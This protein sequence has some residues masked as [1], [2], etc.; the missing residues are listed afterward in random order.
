MLGKTYFLFVLYNKRAFWC[1]LRRAV[2]TS[3]K[4]SVLFILFTDGFGE[5]TPCARYMAIAR[6][7][8]GDVVD[9]GEWNLSQAT[10]ALN[11]SLTERLDVHDRIVTWGNLFAERTRE[12]C[13]SRGVPVDTY[14]NR[15]SGFME[16]LIAHIRDHQWFLSQQLGREV[17]ISE[18]PKYIHVDVV[19][20]D[21]LEPVLTVE[22][23]AVNGDPDATHVEEIAFPVL[24]AQL[25]N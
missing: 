15:L 10:T 1:S 17:G 19:A 8:A 22:F 16:D 14:H 12:V 24:E 2:S 4:V 25:A 6:N 20:D 23:P 9:L 21:P 11:W 18:M 5:R 3:T 7:S 13:R